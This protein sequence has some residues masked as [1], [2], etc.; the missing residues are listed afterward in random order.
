MIAALLT[1]VLVLCLIGSWASFNDGFRQSPN[2]IPL[3]VTISA[4]SGAVFAFGC[5][6]LD[7]KARIF[8]FSLGCDVIM[9]F[10]YYVIPVVFFGV[11][12]KPSVMMGSLLVLAGLLVIQ[13][14]A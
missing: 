8:L 10:A 12:L 11:T 2:F 6:Y 13:L 14:G 1:V 9:V 5:Q 3:M 4:V 7:S